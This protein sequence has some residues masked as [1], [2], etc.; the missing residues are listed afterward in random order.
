MGR[1]PARP[2]RPRAPAALHHAAASSRSP[3]GGCSPAPRVAST[4]MDDEVGIAPDR[5]G[6]V[7][8]ALAR[9]PRMAEIRGRVGLLEGPQH[10]RSEHPPAAPGGQGGTRSPAARSRRTAAPASPGAMAFRIG[11][12]GTSRLSSWATRR[13]IA[14]GSGC[15]WTRNIVGTRADS[16]ALRNLLVGQDHEVFDHSSGSRLDLAMG[17][18]D[19]TSPRPTRSPARA[20]DRQGARPRRRHAGPRPARG[21]RSGWRLPAPFPARRRCGPPSRIR[22]ARPSGSGCR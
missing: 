18:D 20:L 12:V 2:P 4:T 21:Q 3:A 13:S 17:R 15:S 10:E 6:E 5:R 19:L 22:G 8:V 9:E 7:A 11:G 14:A 16:E 1:P